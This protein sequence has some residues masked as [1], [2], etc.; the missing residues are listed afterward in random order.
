MR[1]LVLGTSN[2]ILKNGWLAGFRAA[3]PNASIENR[4]AGASPGIQ[5]ALDAQLDFS[6]YDLVFFDSVPNDEEYAY[7]NALDS[8]CKASLWGEVIYDL[9]ST[10]SAKTCLLILSFPHRNFVAS[11]STVYASRQKIASSL[12]IQFID[13][14]AITNG[15]L[16]ADLCNIKELYGDHPAHVSERLAYE[17]GRYVGIILSEN[18]RLISRSKVASP[19]SDHFRSLSATAISRKIRT[20][21]NSHLTLRTVELNEGYELQLPAGAE[22]LGFA[23]NLAE[24]HCCLQLINTPGT[25]VA[26]YLCYYPFQKDVVHKL[27][28]PVLVKGV[29]GSLR[30]TASNESEA[31]QTIFSARQRDAALKIGFALSAVSFWRRKT[32]AAAPSDRSA[33]TDVLYISRGVLACLT[34]DLAR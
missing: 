3:S 33:N 20:V 32:D 34:R 16:K 17:I 6:K 8:R 19:C 21:R 13:V 15:L 26:E 11:P 23:I 28:L 7:L 10:I 12:G 5:F 18:P 22:C 31:F 4:S 24:T 29:L 14:R 27:F 30:V 2:S 25:K 1:V 9:C